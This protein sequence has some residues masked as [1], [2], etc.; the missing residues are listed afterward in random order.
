VVLA[1]C[2][3]GFGVV[4]VVSSP[5]AGQR[6]STYTQTG[7]EDGRSPRAN[8][9]VRQYLASPNAGGPHGS[10]V[11]TRAVTLAERPDL[12]AQVPDLHTEAWPRFLRQDAVALRYWS[13]LFS[14]FAAY[15]L[16]LH[17]DVASPAGDHRGSVARF[18]YWRPRRRVLRYAHQRAV[19][20]AP[21]QLGHRLLRPSPGHTRP[22]CEAPWKGL[23]SPL[24]GASPCLDQYLGPVHR[25]LCLT[26][27]VAR[28]CSSLPSPVPVG[29]DCRSQRTSI[30]PC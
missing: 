17:N 21:P 14:D 10:V 27:G 23:S 22:T 12:A 18:S 25:M 19:M 13:A 4:F 2:I 16:V 1:W 9:V 30:R 3:R 8:L 20:L 11:Q 29:Q 15:Q 28:F 24:H 26:V 7:T 6:H 5:V